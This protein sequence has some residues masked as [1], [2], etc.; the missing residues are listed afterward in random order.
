M[1]SADA[2]AGWLSRL[3]RIPSVNPVQAGPRAG[4]PGEAAL[5]EALEGWFREL[6]GEVRRQEVLPGRWNLYAMWSGTSDRW[7]AV[8]THMDTVGVEQMTTEPFSGDIRDGR[9]WGRGA[10]DTK[11]TL[12]VVLALLE[13]MQRTGRKPEPNLLIAATVDEEVGARGAPA[14]AA[15]VREQGLALDQLAVSEPTRCA[16]VIGHKGGLRL[17]FVV[18]GEPT[19]S[20]QPHL[21]KNAVTAAARLI[22]AME[23]E[24]ERL[25]SQDA[26]TPV[27]KPTLTV[28]VV[29]GGTG[30][31]VVPDRCSVI[32]DRRMVPGEDVDELQSWLCRLAEDACPLP[33]ET[34]RLKY[35]NAFSQAPDAPWVQALAE[36]GGGAP[37][38]APYGTN[39]W[40]Y[41]G[42]AKEC[43]VI[44]PGSIDQ[45][46]GVEEWVEISELEKITGMYCRW[47][48]LA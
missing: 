37:T 48:G 39:A 46:H 42:L 32:I 28:T 38:A 11:A 9:V 8:D 25:Q 29:Q 44:G 31:N 17:E 6:G 4:T 12:A 10:V 14:F 18:Q 22:L 1:V 33:F 5:A 35:F 47:W 13:A 2:V 30:A 16:P 24:H 23:A 36:W 21:G 15:W 3:V 27:G 19:H 40:A 34:H 41:G 45:A 20:S 7:A 26:A 43:V